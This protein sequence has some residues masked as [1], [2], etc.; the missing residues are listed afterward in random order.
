MKDAEDYPML[1]DHEQP[2]ER[3]H[4]L[5]ILFMLLLTESVTTVSST[6]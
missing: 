5:S 2:E 3:A 1:S 4:S 6:L